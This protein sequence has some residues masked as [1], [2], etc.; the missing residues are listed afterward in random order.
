MSSAPG[1]RQGLSKRQLE[2][3]AIGGAVGAGLFVGSA[4]GLHA[5][6][7]GLLVAYAICGVVVYLIARCL[8][9]LALGHPGQG[10]FVDYIQWQ[11][12]PRWGFVSGWMFW[13]GIVLVGM[14]E[15]TAIGLLLHPWL[16]NLPQWAIVLGVLAGVLLLNQAPVGWFGESEFWLSSLKIATI[17]GFIALA[18]AAVLAPGRF[19]SL[20]VRA[21]DLWGRGL[22]PTGLA[23]FAMAI[24]PT[25]LA[26]GGFELIGLAAAEVADPL[27]TVPRA[28]NGLIARIVIFYM[29]ATAALLVLIPWSRITPE[30]SPFVEVLQRMGLPFAADFI[31]LMLITAIVSSCNSLIFGGSRALHS[32]ATNGNAPKILAALNGRQVPGRAVL[33]TILAVSMAVALNSFV[34][35]RAFGIL[36]QCVSIL[37]TL[38]W[39]LIVLSE[40]RFRR[41]ADPAQA[42]LFPAPWTPWSNLGVI[43]FVVA[44]FAIMAGDSSVRPVFLIAGGL[45]AGLILT[46]AV[47]RRRGAGA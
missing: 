33:L 6:G 28:V 8:G 45:V 40:L 23:G 41:R 2:F 18:I 19:P 7:P 26:F 44:V 13:L 21:V 25:L 11:L 32:L 10:T 15:L 24:P 12:G 35:R 42:I 39:V 20:G 27:R 3:L 14:A 43:P 16:P 30:S 34:P 4:E 29:G 22:F 46:S 9:E 5:A 17:V 31:N 1:L 37:M 38:N 36:M 47:V